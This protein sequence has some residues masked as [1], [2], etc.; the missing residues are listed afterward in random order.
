MNPDNIAITA[1]RQQAL[2]R[3]DFL[4]EG[5]SNVTDILAAM[6]GMM[7]LLGYQEESIRYAVCEIADEINNAG[8]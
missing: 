2:H 5:D 6:L 1:S 8:D 7:R 4:L 3:I